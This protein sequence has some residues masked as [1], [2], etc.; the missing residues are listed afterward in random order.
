MNHHL[1]I[2]IAFIAVGGMLSCDSN[3]G[4]SS[5]SAQYQ[6]LFVSGDAYGRGIYA[7]SVDWRST[8]CVTPSWLLVGYH[9][10]V[11][12]DG[13]FLLFSARA[14]DSLGHWEVNEDIWK[15]S[16]RDS[17]LTRVT[18]NPSFDITPEWISDGTALVFLSGR[19]GRTGLW[20]CAPDGSNQTQIAPDT[21]NIGYLTA[22]SKRPVV[23]YTYGWEFLQ[24]CDLSTMHSFAPFLDTLM[25]DAPAWSPDGMTLAVGAGRSLFLWTI[26]GSLRTI[27]AIGI[28]RNLSWSP[29]GNRIAYAFS[30]TLTVLDL[31]SSSEHRLHT[32]MDYGGR[33]AWSPDGRFI[34]YD[35]LHL[36][37]INIVTADGE[38]VL[39]ISRP[40]ARSRAPRWVTSIW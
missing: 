17:S 34:A 30:D 11:S 21:G 38:Q 13:D 1:T 2:L 10:S 20:M 3:V 14:Q 25:V 37:T 32:N 6:L 28:G 39:E 36:P 15:L 24:V 22:S 7:L 27:D 18:S 26:G 40:G 5:S 29:T 31:S 9:F 16:R 8:R 12:P 23:A 35:Q 33:S 19:T 4:P